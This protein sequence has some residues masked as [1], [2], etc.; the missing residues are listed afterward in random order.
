M[1]GSG[2]RARVRRSSLRTLAAQLPVLLAATA[3]ADGGSTNVVLRD[4]QGRQRVPGGY[5]AITEHGKATIRYTPA[6]YR[7]VVRMGAP[8]FLHPGLS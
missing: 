6:D 2:L 5:V 4:E 1:T 7:R 3:L 8:G